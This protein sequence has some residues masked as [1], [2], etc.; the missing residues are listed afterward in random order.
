M[1]NK[2]AAFTAKLWYKLINKS[3]TYELIEMNGKFECPICKDNVKNVKMHFEK[4]LA[5]GQKIDIDHFEP[6]HA[7]FK[8]EKRNYQIQRSKAKSKD[9]DS[10]NFIKK[11]NAATQKSQAKSK[12]IDQQKFIEKRNTATQKS[13]AKSKDI[14]KQKFRNKKNTAK[15]K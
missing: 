5:C 12:D 13:E 10:Q 8:K 7:E 14:D 1:K 15:Q 2:D 3:S 4:K 11:R 9:E 6:I